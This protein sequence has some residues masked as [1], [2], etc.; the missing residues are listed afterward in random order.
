[1]KAI[2]VRKASDCD[3][4]REVT[5]ELKNEGNEGKPYRVT[6]EVELS[7]K[8]YKK[9]TNDLLQ[10]QAFIQNDEG[11]IN[12][13]GEVLCI[14]VINKV[15]RERILIDPQGYEYPRYTAIEESNNETKM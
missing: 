12:D 14:R 8:A 5:E 1:M 15:S 6:R 10:D 3:V 11:G 7:D 4:V 13:E 2:F 9:L